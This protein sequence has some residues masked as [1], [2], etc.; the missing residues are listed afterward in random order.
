MSIEYKGNSDVLLY[1]N[2]RAIDTLLEGGYQCK[3]ELIVIPLNYQFPF[4]KMYL[5]YATN[6]ETFYEN[7]TL[8]NSIL[9]LASYRNLSKK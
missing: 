8:P 1:G 2:P 5:K 6:G 9:K 3:H 4:I 7:I